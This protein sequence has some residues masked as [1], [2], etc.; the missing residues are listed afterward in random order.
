MYDVGAY[1]QNQNAR[2]QLQNSRNERKTVS[3]ELTQLHGPH[4]LSNDCVVFRVLNRACRLDRGSLSAP[5]SPPTAAAPLAAPTPQPPGR[6]AQAARGRGR[7]GGGGGGIGGCTAQ[8]LKSRRKTKSEESQETNQKI[9]YLI[10]FFAC[11]A[12]ETKTKFGAQ[13]RCTTQ[14]ADCSFAAMS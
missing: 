2:M 12:G 14:G 4:N 10:L 13:R 6:S 9:L 11:G 1:L 5:S 3:A 7:A 8:K